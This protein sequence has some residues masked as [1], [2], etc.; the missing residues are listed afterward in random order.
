MKTRVLCG[1]RGSGLLRNIK[2]EISWDMSVHERPFIA[3]ASRR[4]AGLV[5]GG[6]QGAHIASI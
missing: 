1:A 2:N 4:G 5:A 6:L 3:G